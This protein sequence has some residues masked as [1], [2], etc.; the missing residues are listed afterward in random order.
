MNAG[1]TDS[2]HPLLKKLNIPPLYSQHIFSLSTFVVTNINAFKWKSATHSINTRQ[3]YD[4]HRPKTNLTKA[5]KGV[6]YSGI[7]I[8]IIYH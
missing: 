8:S 3:G 1:Y 4:L 5:Q 7:K 2:F 6:C